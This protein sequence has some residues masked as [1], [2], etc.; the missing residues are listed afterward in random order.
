MVDRLA[1]ADR[2]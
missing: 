1:T 2:C